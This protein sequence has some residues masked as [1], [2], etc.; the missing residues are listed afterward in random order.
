MIDARVFERPRKSEDGA[1]GVLG[2]DVPSP[3]GTGC[4]EDRFMALF[5]FE[6]GC[7]TLDEVGTAERETGTDWTVIVLGTVSSAGIASGA[8]NSNPRATATS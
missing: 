3:Y 8:G 1:E 4:D 2:D 5:V 7:M 6:N